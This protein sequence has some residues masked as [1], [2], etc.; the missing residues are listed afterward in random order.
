MIDARKMADVKEKEKVI[1]SILSLHPND[2]ADITTIRR[3]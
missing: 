2:G 1:V 3:K